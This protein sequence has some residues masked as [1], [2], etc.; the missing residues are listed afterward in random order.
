MQQ[1]FDKTA[2][3]EWLSLLAQAP[4]AILEAWTQSG[5]PSHSWIRRPETGLVMVRARVGGTGNK[6][7]FG[8]VP[9]TRC[10]VRLESGQAGIA[11]IQGRSK[12]KAEL[13][14]IADA[15]LQ[16][17]DCFDRIAKDLL[18]PIRARLIELAAKRTSDANATRVEFFTLVRGQG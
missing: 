13:V 3:Q 10:A 8:E 9:M 14:A 12:R 11:Y 5:I 1:Q 16:S 7:N 17:P 4:I 15:M 18:E 2:R 6:F